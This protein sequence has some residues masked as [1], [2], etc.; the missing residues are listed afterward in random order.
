MK[1]I[2]W[3]LFLPMLHVCVEIPFITLRTAVMYRNEA[4][5]NYQFIVLYVR[6]WKWKFDIRLYDTLERKLD[7]QP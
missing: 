5:A 1:K 3:R 4:E 7:R 6:V 2:N